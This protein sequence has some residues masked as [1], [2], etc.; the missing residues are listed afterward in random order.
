[1]KHQSKLALSTLRTLFLMV[2]ITLSSQTSNAQVG[3][4]YDKAGNRISCYVLKMASA[5]EKQQEEIVEHFAGQREIAL[6]PNPTKGHLILNIANGEE[7]ETYF[8][9]LFNMSGHLLLQQ[10]RTGNGTFEMNIENQ[11]SGT[12]ILILATKEDKIHYK[13][14]KN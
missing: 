14:I 10:Q 8:I 12:Y 2:I 6:Y 3:Y 1:M 7:E 9:S 13:I 5:G 11:P 4:T